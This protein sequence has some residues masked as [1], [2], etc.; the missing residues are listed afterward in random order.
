MIEGVAATTGNIPALRRGFKIRRSRSRRPLV[1]SCFDLPCVD[2]RRQHHFVLP[3]PEPP[4]LVIE[5]LF[6][7]LA[8]ARSA[9]VARSQNTYAVTPAPALLLLGS[10]AGVSAG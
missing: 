2:A 4:P 8:P 10:S 3:R 7:R 9:W 5:R 6:D 1:E